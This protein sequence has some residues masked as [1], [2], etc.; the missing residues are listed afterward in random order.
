MQQKIQ[1]KLQL[2]PQDFMKYGTSIMESWRNDEEKKFIYPLQMGGDVVGVPSICKLYAT[3]DALKS[4]DNTAIVSLDNVPF[5]ENADEGLTKEIKIEH[6]T[7]DHKIS[8]SYTRARWFFKDPLT[9]LV[10][11]VWLPL[12][13]ANTDISQY[14]KF[15]SEFTEAFMDVYTFTNM[16]LASN[17]TILD[18]NIRGLGFEYFEKL[19]GSTNTDPN[20]VKAITAGMVDGTS[21]DEI[22]AEI[23]KHEEAKTSALIFDYWL[24]KGMSRYA[25]KT[26]E[27]SKDIADRMKDGV[28]EKQVKIK[29]ADVAPVIAKNVE[30]SLINI[31]QPAAK[32][33]S[34]YSLI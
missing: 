1:Q 2:T 34:T 25:T 18:A 13:P 23:K 33:A 28:P 27:I 3:V 6:G 24:R 29:S 7:A 22:N 15:V 26:R 31:G 4:K 10:Q 21:T 16:M 12:I 20:T 9:G 30:P 5:E 11:K 8:L 14:L 19:V 17:K 32:N